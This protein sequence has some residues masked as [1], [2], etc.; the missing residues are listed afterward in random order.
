MSRVPVRQ[1]G[2]NNT[3][4]YDNLLILRHFDDSVFLWQEQRF[5]RSRRQDQGCILLLILLIFLQQ[6]AQFKLSR[7]KVRGK[8]DGV[9]WFN[10]FE[11]VQ[12]R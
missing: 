3:R 10:S 1:S 6:D 12:A 4:E 7:R 8:K 11:I 5:I 9:P 2:I